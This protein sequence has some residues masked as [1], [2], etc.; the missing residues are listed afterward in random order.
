MGQDGRNP[1]FQD[2]FD[3]RAQAGNAGDIGRPRFKDRRNL[4]R[5]LLFK[6]MDAVPTG[7]KKAGP[8]R[9]GG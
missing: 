2:E 5:L 6:G 4:W 8:R 1:R 7:N 9:R 3:S